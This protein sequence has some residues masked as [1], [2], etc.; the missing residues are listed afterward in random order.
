MFGGC[1][2]RRSRPPLRGHVFHAPKAYVSRA[3]RKRGI[4]DETADHNNVMRSRKRIF[5]RTDEVKQQ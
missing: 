2:N 1:S 5:S 4:I 3:S